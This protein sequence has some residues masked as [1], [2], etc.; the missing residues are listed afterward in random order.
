LES[1]YIKIIGASNYSDSIEVDDKNDQK[2]DTPLESANTDKDTKTMK[3]V[4]LIRSNSD[5]FILQLH[6]ITLLNEHA[7]NPIAQENIIIRLTFII[8]IFGNL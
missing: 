7:I 2:I 5:F 4:P 3:E 6:S 8:E 1:D